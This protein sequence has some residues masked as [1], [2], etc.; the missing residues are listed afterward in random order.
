M[1]WRGSPE[2]IQH[3]RAWLDGSLLAAAVAT[4]AA[5]QPVRVRAEEG[6]GQREVLE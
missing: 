3:Q 6:R 2:V 5:A 1:Y 4:A